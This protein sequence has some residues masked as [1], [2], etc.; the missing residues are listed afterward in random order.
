MKGRLIGKVEIATWVIG[1]TVTLVTAGCAADPGST[2]EPPSATRFDPA[3]RAVR[4]ETTGC[5]F[6]PD[7]TG[8]GVAIGDGLVL[9]VAHLVAQ[10]D[11]VAVTLGE[12]GAIDA[13]VAA[14]DLELDLALLRVPKNGVPAVDI[15]SADRG[16]RGLVVGGATSG[17]VAFE[18][19]DVVRIS[20]E[21]V[22]G[23]DRHKRLGYELAAVTTTGDSGAGAYDD[24]SRLIGIVFATSD[25]GATTW[26]TA[27]GEIETFLASQDAEHGA[28]LCDEEI[29]R[30]DL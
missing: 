6:A 15:S 3:A 9:T 23:S 12:S 5:G 27:S 10:A 19:A 11:G 7:R 13:A 28:I 29:S 30:L 18:V 2:T 1:A 22:L 24:D 20:I 26:I 17:T 21:E 4:I 25:G 14:A 8:S 16:D